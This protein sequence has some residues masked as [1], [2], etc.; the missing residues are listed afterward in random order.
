MVFKIPF[1][2]FIFIVQNYR[3]QLIHI[4]VYKTVFPGSNL[5]SINLGNDVVSVKMFVILVVGVLS[6]YTCLKI[7]LLSIGVKSNVI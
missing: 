1:H 3:R 2:V 4:L 6:R 7:D 5:H